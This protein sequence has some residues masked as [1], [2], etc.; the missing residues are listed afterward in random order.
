[1]QDTAGRLIVT[2]KST[3][4]GPDG[5]ISTVAGI[6]DKLWV[7]DV[8]IAVTYRAGAVMVRA[9]GIVREH[10]GFDEILDK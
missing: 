7:R 10:I 3:S 1:M 4:R 8:N 6:R 5:G 2:L 9:N